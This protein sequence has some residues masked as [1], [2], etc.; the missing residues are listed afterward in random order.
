MNNLKQNNPFLIIIIFLLGFFG[1]TSLKSII[2]DN[3]QSDGLLTNNLKHSIN[4]GFNTIYTLVSFWLIKKYKLINLAG[5]GPF[6]PLKN[7]LLLLF[8]LYLV[9]VNILFLDDID[10]GSIPMLDYILLIVW[11]VSV[12]FSEEYM[13]RGFTQSTLLKRF[14]K[15]KKGIVYSVIGAAFI[16]GL[17]HLLKFD[18]GLYGEIAQVF[19]ATFIGTMFGALLLRTHKIWPLVVLHAVIDIAGN[20]DKLATPQVVKKVA[21]AE[22]DLI[23]SIA[24]TIIVLPCFIYGLILLRK[25]KVEDFTKKLNVE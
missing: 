8:P 24:I 2:L 16:F 7:K 3:L 4:I 21:E 22:G 14:G 25:V 17:L 19:F 1:L 9:L 6:F 13:L 20:L 11:A 12:G 15:T 18:K 23:N 5:L 10:Y